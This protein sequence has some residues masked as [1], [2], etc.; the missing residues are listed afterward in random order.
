VRGVRGRIAGCAVGKDNDTDASV[1]ELL[2]RMCCRRSRERVDVESARIEIA[3]KPEPLSMGHDH[4]KGILAS[5]KLWRDGSLVCWVGNQDH[6]LSKKHPPAS[7]QLTSKCFK[8]G[9]F[10]A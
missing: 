4:L 3:V 10:P 1:S 8:S 6:V 9:A 2:V 7:A 5:E